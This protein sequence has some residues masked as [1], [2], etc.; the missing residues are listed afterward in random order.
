MFSVGRVLI[1]ASPSGK[2]SSMFTWGQKSEASTIFISKTTIWFQRR[3]A[4]VPFTC[5]CRRFKRLPSSW[6]PSSV[7]SSRISRTDTFAYRKPFRVPP[8]TSTFIR[9]RRLVRWNGH[10]GRSSSRDVA[11]FSSRGAGFRKPGPLPERDRMALERGPVA[12]SVFVRLFA[13][14]RTNSSASSA[15]VLISFEAARP[16][17]NESRRTRRVSLRVPWKATLR[18]LTFVIHSR[19]FLFFI[20]V[21]DR[22]QER[23]RGLVTIDSRIVVLFLLVAG[24]QEDDGGRVIVASIVDLWRSRFALHFSSGH[25]TAGRFSPAQLTVTCPTGT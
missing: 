5:S 11:L 12:L 8:S 9:G 3:I 16:S 21:V 22:Q 20:I 2:N 6:K 7:A 23:D 10:E 19:T 24:Q 13:D 18:L 14:P 15:L 1:I 25:S 17:G 4:D